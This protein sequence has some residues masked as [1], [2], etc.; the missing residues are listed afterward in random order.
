MKT[1][2]KDL[3]NF[4][5]EIYNLQNIFIKKY[6]KEMYDGEWYKDDIYWIADDIGGTLAVADY[7]F[8]LQRI[9]DAIKYNAPIK[10]FFNYYDEELELA[11]EDK[12]MTMNFKNYI[13]YKK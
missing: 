1:S 9:V 4:E 3:I 5:K 11:M 10:K 2:K 8:S 12:P 7:F 6:F 13:K